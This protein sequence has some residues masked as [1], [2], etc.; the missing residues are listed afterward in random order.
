VSLSKIYVG[1]DVHKESITIAALLPGKRD[2]ESVVK[3]E[4]DLR[5]VRRH[6]DRLAKHGEI[7]ACYEASGAGYV[8]QRAMKEWSY[9]CEVVAPSL[10]PKRAGDRRKTDVRDA[11]DLAR[12]YRSGDLVTVHIPTESEER[13]RDL[14]RCREAMQRNLL[15]ARH[16]VTKFLAR[17]GLVYRE[18]A[19]WHTK[20]MSWLS[21]LRKSELLEAQDH[22]VFDEYLSHLEYVES[23]RDALDAAIETAAQ[24]P[25]YKSRVDR[26]LSFHGINIHTAMVLLT[27][28]G[29]FQ[30]FKSPR[31]LMGFLGLVP[32][33]FSS[34]ERERRGSITKTGNSRV[35]HV[36]V[37]AA[38]NQS[39]RPGNVGYALKKRREGQPA[40][41][42]AHAMKARTRLYQRF[43][44]L[45]AR[46][47]APIAAVAVA[48][49][50]SGFIWAVM[51]DDIPIAQQ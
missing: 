46:K 34:G 43:A 15:R 12:H 32:R 13:V 50:M 2:P 45:M 11:V 7:A 47:G 41:V 14:V 16:Q 23:R 19:R 18:G 3:L 37:Q 30:R 21:K 5:K 29:D 8:L 48:R 33:E 35:R 26:L 49:E 17:R 24:L 39:R 22:F 4:H 10:I 6:L 9:S 25:Q 51:R 20:H 28:V 27:E 31:D 44:K 40:H 36:L 38:W 42:V 1:I